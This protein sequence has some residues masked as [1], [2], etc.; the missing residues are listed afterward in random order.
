M[1]DMKDKGRALFGTKWFT[2][3]LLGLGALG[4]GF[5]SLAFAVPTD[6]W[7]MME[8]YFHRPLLLFLNFLPPVVLVYFLWFL[9]NRALA[10]YG[11][12]A[13]VVF[14]LSLANWYKLQFRNDPLMFED[15]F[16]A[17]EA[18]AML[19]RY[20][21]FITP[22]LA[23][24]IFCILAGGAAVFFCGRG[25]FGKGW[26]RFALA[27]AL[28]VL[29]LPLGRLYA[30]NDVYVNRV[31]NF[32]HANRWSS[33][34]VYTSKGFL[35]PFLHSA[36]SAFETAPE[37]Y[38]KKEA[39][40]ILA[41]YQDAPIPEDRRVDVIGIMLEAYSDLSYY[42]QIPFAKDPYEKYHALEKES[43][44]G[45]LVTNIFAGGT[46]ATERSFLTGLME[47]GKL[48]GQTNSYAWYFGGQGYETQGSHPAYSWIYNR[49]NINANLGFDSYSFYEDRYR[50]LA[51]GDIAMD[52]ILLPE[53]ANIYKETAE[54]GSWC[55]SFS[56]TY[57]GHGPYQTD[58][59]RWGEN[60]VR[61]GE[62][63]PETE[64]ILNN[65]LGSVQSTGE[66]LWKF[67]D[68][69]RELER[70]VVIV[71][72]GDHKPWLGDGNS[73]Y[74]ELG[75]DLQQD[76]KEGFLNYY[77]T[78]Y[79]IWANDAAKKKLGNDFTGEGQAIAPCFLMNQVFRLCGW[80]GPAYMQY[81][82]ELMDRLPVVHLTGACIS[83]E[84]EFIPKPQ[85]EDAEK[86]QELRRVEYY[87]RHEFLYGG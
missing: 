26:L 35:Y 75:V 87:M 56:V 18:G 5:L 30:D 54:D 3:L 74:T 2:G 13:A 42:P 27:G 23:A 58:E 16:L 44:T 66:E 24:S 6:R 12:T 15:L 77:G 25:R 62:L 61:P 63:T 22:M 55:F 46:V 52:D 29:A 28:L 51:G 64:N 79:L 14:L 86:I 43:F 32:D 17:K 20:Q 53:I 4:V 34:E 82:S 48:R 67:V 59:N 45:D 69:Y 36:A 80:Q 38:N 57:Q 33:T 40:E 68:Q 1:L 37:G 60:F 71:V 10:A 31:Q 19:G 9:T 11:A 65:Y 47:P 73:V 76:H 85:G 72:F 8:D 70:P 49:L 39:R 83:R 81:T 84:G 50:D 7:V 21:L 78:R 41:G